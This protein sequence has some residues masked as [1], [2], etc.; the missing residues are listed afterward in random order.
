M[1]KQQGASKLSKSEKKK[2]SSQLCEM[3]RQVNPQVISRIV[4]SCSSFD[5]ALERTLQVAE[6]KSDDDHNKHQEKEEAKEEANLKKEEDQVFDDAALA[7]LFPSSSSAQR[8]R[9][10]A[11]SAGCAELAVDL[12]ASLAKEDDDNEHENANA[13]A[14]SVA[15]LC[16]VFAL[17][18]SQARAELLASQNRFEEAAMNI[19]RRS[20]H[21]DHETKEHEGGSS[22]SSNSKSADIAFLRAMFPR[23]SEDILQG[24][25]EEMK[26]LEDVVDFLLSLDVLLLEEA[27]SV[28]DSVSEEPQPAGEEEVLAEMFPQ[29][30]ADARL[31]ALEACSWDVNEACAVLSAAQQVQQ[32]KKK[33]GKSSKR[34]QKLEAKQIRVGASSR[35][36]GSNAIVRECLVESKV[37]L[38]EV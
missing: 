36:N 33:I 25:L 11:L 29:L 37:S 26:Q 4:G 24:L 17:S 1:S 15:D 22:S 27:M 34:W 16:E 38:I 14:R 10:L 8:G 19:L 28:P 2:I 30:D 9:A 5:E 21:E 3:F 7:S 6:K 20:K 23:E 13:L 31:A 12:M 35:W 18:P 32:P